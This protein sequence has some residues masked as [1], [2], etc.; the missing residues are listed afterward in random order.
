MR[1][2]MAAILLTMAMVAPAMAQ[3]AEPK[4]EKQAYTDQ[5]EQWRKSQEASLKAERG[6]LSVAGLYWLKPGDNTIGTASTEDVVLPAGSAPEKVGVVSLH[7]G[8]VTLT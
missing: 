2:F 3:T 8:T 1:Y 5:I 7:D 4:I 6:W